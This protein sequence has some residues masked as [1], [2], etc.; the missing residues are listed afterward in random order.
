MFKFNNKDIQNDAKQRR[1][2]V[3]IVKFEHISQL[4]LVFI[5]LILCR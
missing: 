5:L 2:G 3:F 4:D 1:S